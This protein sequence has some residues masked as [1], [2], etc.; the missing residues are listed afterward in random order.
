VTEDEARAEYEASA[1][2]AA[3]ES[4][5]TQSHAPIARL[6][7]ESGRRL[8]HQAQDLEHFGGRAA[9]LTAC[10]RLREAARILF[11]EA[12]AQERADEAVLV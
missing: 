10:S 4:T 2:Y 8:V 3:I 6:L 11:R 9:H 5:R 12:D 7:R 1:E